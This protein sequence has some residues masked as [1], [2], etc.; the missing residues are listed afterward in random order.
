MTPSEWVLVAPTILTVAG[1]EF[2]VHAGGQHIIVYN[3]DRRGHRH[4]YHLWPSTGRWRH[5]PPGSYAGDWG[6]GT[7]TDGRR[8]SA[9]FGGVRGLVRYIQE[10]LAD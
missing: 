4:E 9:K 2:T 5:K 3:T 10:V 1:L 6:I 8:V 7:H